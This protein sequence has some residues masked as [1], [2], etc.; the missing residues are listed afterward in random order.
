MNNNILNFWRGDIKLWKSYWI[1]GELI[2]AI[3]LVVIVNIELRFFKNYQL[4]EQIPIFNF[5]DINF[6]NKIILLVWTVFISVGMWRS[7]EKYRGRLI[8]IILTLIVV[9]YR[10]FI[11]REIIY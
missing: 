8:W 7:A 10:I 6:I 11:L 5:N 9:S 4:L 3:V 1:V 2:N